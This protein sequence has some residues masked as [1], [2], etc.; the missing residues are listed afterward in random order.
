MKAVLKRN[1]PLWI[2]LLLTLIASLVSVGTIACTLVTTMEDAT[3]TTVADTE[4]TPTP[5]AVNSD[6]KAEA[7]P[8]PTAVPQRA[9]TVALPTEKP[10]G[11]YE[12][13]IAEKVRQSLSL[14]SYRRAEWR[15]VVP[16]SAHWSWGRYVGPTWNFTY[17]DLS[18]KEI[19]AYRSAASEWVEA[20]LAVPLDDNVLVSILHDPTGFRPDMVQVADYNRET[21]V[22][23]DQETLAL[24][25]LDTYNIFTAELRYDRGQGVDQMN[26]HL[27]TLHFTASEVR[28]MCAEDVS[29]LTKE[30]PVAEFETFRDRIV[31]VRVYPNQACW[32]EQVYFTADIRNHKDYIER[33]ASEPL[34]AKTDPETLQQHNADNLTEAEAVTLAKAFYKQATGLEFTGELT[35]EAYLDQSGAREDYWTV[36]FDGTLL[37]MKLA[38]VSGHLMEMSSS[39]LCPAPNSGLAALPEN[40]RDAIDTWDDAY[41]SYTKHMSEWFTVA[42]RNR[43]GA[44]V[45][46]VD[47]NAEVDGHVA[48]LDIEM[49]D[50]SIYELEYDWGK[51]R[52]VQF[53]PCEEAFGNGPAGKWP[54][55]F[56]YRQ[57]V[58]GEEVFSIGP[59]NW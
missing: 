30:G 33:I 17:M 25:N 57:L 54:A 24:I 28:F 53:Y 13:Q 31:S 10:A 36:A 47:W 42:G 45:V 1:K 14:A 34:F 52:T 37:Q 49:S 39:G 19:D 3:V 4:A 55:D 2:S 22:T 11:D 56:L 51:L 23:M 21:I 8:P 6:S 20:V 15:G 48:T 26:E 27:K 5:V 58:T 40:T 18:D 7:V 44:Q 35:V 32:E 29:V 38:A 41:L 46:N 59:V 50:G 16:Q 9:E 43:E 12:Q